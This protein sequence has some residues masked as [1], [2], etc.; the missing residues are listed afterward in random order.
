MLTFGSAASVTAVAFPFVADCSSC[1]A[2]LSGPNTV[3]PSTE[4]TT[5]ATT[6]SSSTAPTMIA[7]SR[8]RFFLAG[9]MGSRGGRV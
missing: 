7:I 5:A 3:R 6:A 9:S 4:N 1:S 8:I 2:C